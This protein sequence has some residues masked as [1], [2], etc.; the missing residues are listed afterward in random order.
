M[1]DQNKIDQIHTLENELFEE[2]ATNNFSYKDLLWLKTRINTQKF[3]PYFEGQLAQICGNIKCKNF[4]VFDATNDD[5]E[6]FEYKYTTLKNDTGRFPQFIRP[7]R[8]IPDWYV[9]IMFDGNDLIVS[10]IIGAELHDSIASRQARAGAHSGSN[11][12]HLTFK[13]YARA[14]MRRLY[15]DV[16]QYFIDHRDPYIEGLIRN[17]AFSPIIVN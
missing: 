15:S 2:L 5:G 7:T 11:E 13:K 12:L 3:S 9:L 8:A 16:F 14:P 4:A 10:K 1:L 17:G 6:T